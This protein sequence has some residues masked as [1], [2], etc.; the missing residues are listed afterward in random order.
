[1]NDFAKITPNQIRYN[2][3]NLRQLVFEVTDACNLNC[4]YCAYS[5]LY[6]GYDKRENINLPFQ[7]A[8]L[9]IDYLYEF[10]KE[11]QPKDMDKR[12]SIAFYGG[13]PLMNFTFIKEVISYVEALPPISRIFEY[14]M[15]TNGVLL[16]RYM[17][18]LVEKDFVIMVSLDGDEQGHSYRTWKN[19]SNSFHTVFKNVKLLQTKYPAFFDTNVSFNSV[20]HDRNSIDSSYSFFAEQFGKKT[21][22]VPLSYT[23]INPERWD[24]FCEIFQGITENLN[25]SRN[26]KTLEHE[27]F[28]NI[29]KT[30][31]L[32]NYIR[33]YSN[34]VFNS[35]SDLLFSKN[36]VRICPTGTCSPFQKKMFVTAKGRILSCEKIRHEFE[37]GIVTDEKVEMNVEQV[38]NKQNEYTFKYIEQCKKCALR[39][40]CNVCIFQTD[41]TPYNNATCRNFSTQEML[42]LSFAKCMEHL[43][44]NPELYNKIL[45]ETIVR[46]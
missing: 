33:L 43:E 10:W 21:K 12:V 17:D 46:S 39:S 4:K 8:K 28:L 27:L 35:Y 13:E 26:C 24:E 18:F 42:E 1:M 15:T 45:K 25:Q 9:I 40:N 20:I 38:A 23:N 14:N 5:D 6:T 11:S 22:F 37:L 36:K 3:I 29:P 16:D 34:N 30:Y 2:L 32:M 41:D 7:K 44:E 31:S 19:G